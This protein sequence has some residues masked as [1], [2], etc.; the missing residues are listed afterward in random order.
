MLYRIVSG[1]LQNSR[2]FRKLRSKAGDLRLDSSKHDIKTFGIAPAGLEDKGLSTPWLILKN[3]QKKKIT[4]K[5]RPTEKLFFLFFSLCTLN[6][7][8]LY[9]RLLY[10]TIKIYQ[11]NIGVNMLSHTKQRRLYRSGGRISPVIPFIRE[12][13]SPLGIVLRTLTDIALAYQSTLYWN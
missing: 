9:I 4:S 13:N 1:I 6:I 10:Y 5:K 2:F 3:F 12:W 8:I 7:L 11:K